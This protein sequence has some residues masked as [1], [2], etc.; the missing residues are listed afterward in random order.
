[1]EKL[2]SQVNL[3]VAFLE[4][5]KAIILS[6]GN[7]ILSLLVANGTLTPDV[8]AALVALLSALCGGA[9][10]VGKSQGFKDFKLGRAK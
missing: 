2:L 4:G 3:I 10:V 5:K 8:G 1:M 9:L 6:I 7:P